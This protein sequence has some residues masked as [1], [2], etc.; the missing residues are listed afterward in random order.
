VKFFEGPS[1]GLSNGH[2]DF[3]GHL[4]QRCRISF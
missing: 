2:E 1:D 3:Q 4:L